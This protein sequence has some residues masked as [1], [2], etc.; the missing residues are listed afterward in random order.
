MAKKKKY[1]FKCNKCG[2]EWKSA[3]KPEK[4]I[5]RC[6]ANCRNWVNIST[7][8][9]DKHPPII[10]EIVEMP[11]IIEIPKNPGIDKEQYPT[12]GSNGKINDPVIEGDYLYLIPIGGMS[13][14]DYL[15]RIK[16]EVESKY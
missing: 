9:N 14:E 3:R 8:N 12:V 1:H 4:P 7:K 13:R 15:M 11:D 6:K 2:L 16:Q 5:K 10:P